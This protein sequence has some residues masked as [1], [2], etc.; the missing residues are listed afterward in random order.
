MESVKNKNKPLLD[1]SLVKQL[2][3]KSSN[4]VDIKKSATL[5]VFARAQSAVASGSGSFYE[6]K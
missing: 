5:F 6:R 3:F 2:Y 4:N 1:H